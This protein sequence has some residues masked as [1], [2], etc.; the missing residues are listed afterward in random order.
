LYFLLSLNYI[1]KCNMMGYST[2][3][4]TTEEMWGS[5]KVQWRIITAETILKKN[6]FTILLTEYSE[7]YDKKSNFKYAPPF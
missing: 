7:D 1:S 5:L 2:I 4:R 3:A 6:M